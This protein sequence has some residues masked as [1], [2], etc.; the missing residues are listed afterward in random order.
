MTVLYDAPKCYMTND[1]EGDNANRVVPHIVPFD[2]HS[3]LQVLETLN[4]EPKDTTSK[5]R[6]QRS[7]AEIAES[8]RSD[9]S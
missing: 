7:V 5:G 8:N 9:E 3:E 4:G 6:P 1:H 2:G